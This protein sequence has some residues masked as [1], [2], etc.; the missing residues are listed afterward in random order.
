M[1]G[2]WVCPVLPRAPFQVA[3]TGRGFVLSYFQLTAAFHLTLRLVV[4]PDG[5]YSQG[6]M[7]TMDLGNEAMAAWLQHVAGDSIVQW[8]LK[9]C[10]VIGDILESIMAF[11][12]LTTEW[13]SPA[14]DLKAMDFVTVPVAYQIW[15]YIEAGVRMYYHYTQ[16]GPNWMAN[17]CPTALKKEPGT[18]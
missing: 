14:A 5:T 17:F 11:C 3:P 4:T 18:A 9:N 13:H 12:Q 1:L 16:S 15:A 2:K 10:E 7:F 6:A 8:N